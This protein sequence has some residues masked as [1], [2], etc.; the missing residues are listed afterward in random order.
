MDFYL[1]LQGIMEEKS[2]KIPDIARKC[3]LSDGTIRSAI[4]RKQKNVSLDVAFK[5][6]DGLGV[7]LERLNG[8]PEKVIT[9]VEPKGSKESLSTGEVA[10]GDIFT[11]IKQKLGEDTHDA[12]SMYVQLD[13]DDRGEVRGEMKQMLK[14]DKYKNT[15]CSKGEPAEAV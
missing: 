7:S 3:G 5:L 6:S 4:V 1:I 14:A 13:R 8:M 10:P 15:P 9:S 11:N 12:V 2:L